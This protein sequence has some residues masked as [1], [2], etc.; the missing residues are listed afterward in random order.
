MLL[1][2]LNLKRGEVK[3]LGQLPVSGNG[4]IDNWEGL[5]LN[6]EKVVVKVLRTG[7][8]SL[9]VFYFHGCGCLDNIFPQRFQRE[10]TIWYNLWNQDQGEH[11]LPFYGNKSS[12]LFH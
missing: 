5:Y 6:K 8:K 7:A 1:P 11:I 9:K 4:T 3:R 2:D 10:V 12:F